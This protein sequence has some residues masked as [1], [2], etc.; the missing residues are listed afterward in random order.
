MRRIKYNVLKLKHMKKIFNIIA[1]AALSLGLTTSCSD[2]FLDVTPTGVA[3]GETVNKQSGEVSH[4]SL[5]H[6]GR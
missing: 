2:D 4:R 3:D 5:C 6:T 1:I